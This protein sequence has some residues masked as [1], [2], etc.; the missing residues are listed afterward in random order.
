MSLSAAIAVIVV[1]DVAVLGF[2]AW[3]MSHPRHLIPH[4][5]AA[6]IPATDGRTGV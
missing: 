2:L 6:R 5:R 4:V 1:M 3:M